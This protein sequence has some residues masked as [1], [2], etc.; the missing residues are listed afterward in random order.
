[1]LSNIQ[2]IRR[3]ATAGVIA[4]GRRIAVMTKRR[5]GMRASRRRATAAP[6]TSSMATAALV[7]RAVTPSASQ[8]AS[9]LRM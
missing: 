1:L 4:M 9:S 3:P 8:K 5:H 6:R 7:N 2:R